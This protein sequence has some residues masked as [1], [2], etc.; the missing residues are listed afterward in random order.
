MRLSEE[1]RALRRGRAPVTRSAEPWVPRPRPRPFPTDWARTPAASAARVIVRDLGLRTLTW[2]STRPRVHGADLLAGIDGPVV[3]A[4][5]HASHLDTPLILGSLPPRLRR[6]V[7]VGAAAD[8]F[9]DA[10]WRA[11]ATALAFNAFPIDRNGTGRPLD[12][13]ARLL[14]DGWHVLLYPEGTRSRDGWMRRFRLGAAVLCTDLGV[15]A[16][17]VVVRGTYQAMPRGGHWPRP[18]RPAVTVRYGRPVAPREGESVRE[19]GARLEDAVGRLWVEHDEG[20]WNALR[21]PV[22]RLTPRG[23]AAAPWRRIWES[24]RPVPVARRRVWPR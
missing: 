18:G 15:P 2:T 22:P 9:F 1:I 14:R 4:A 13:A 19:F 24:T 7:A 11:A 3:F 8:Y 21:A 12:L 17:P 20:W 10:R 16:V 5:N 6:D 23:P